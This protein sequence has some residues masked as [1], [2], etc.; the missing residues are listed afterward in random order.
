MRRAIRLAA[1]FG[2]AALALSAI[3]ASAFPGRDGFS[4]QR[5]P[6]VNGRANEYS[7]AADGAYVS[8]TASGVRRH[9]R[10]RVY[11]SV[12]GG[13]R[14]R[15]NAPGTKGWNGGIEGT[16]L[17]FTQYGG[18]EADLV[19]Y[20]MAT[21][22]VLP[23]PEGVNTDLREFNPT[24]SGDHLFFDRDGFG[25]GNRIEDIVLF[26]T[27]T[28]TET[29][30]VHN[31]E[32]NIFHSVGQVNGNWAV[33]FRCDFS[34]TCDVM[35]YDIDGDVT[36]TAP[37]L[38]GLQQYAPSVTEDGTVYFVRSRPACG[39]RVRYMVWDGVSDPTLFNDFRQGRDSYDNFFD[40][41]TDTLYYERF[42]CG[43]GSSGIFKKPA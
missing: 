30:L 8:W 43:G 12:D 11:F 39:D 6:V 24:I 19:L 35:R 23:L 4:R 28:E 20:D 9:N 41:T 10:F 13:E 27:A 42:R 2:A 26:N 25:G 32:N 16:H 7:P 17:V 21:Q 22:T 38:D 14:Q 34:G 29:I 15:A 18:G 5:V 1:I 40:E 36:V 33:Y 31:E 37:N 3:P